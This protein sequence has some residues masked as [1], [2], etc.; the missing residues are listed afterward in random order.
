MKV[1][2]AAAL[3][4]AIVLTLGVVVT[5][6]QA[7]KTKK[8]ATEGEVEGFR[9]P[10]GELEFYGD[11]HSRKSKCEKGREV[12]LLYHGP[13]PVDDPVVGTDVTDGTGDW[14]VRSPEFALEGNYA[15]E[16][17]RKKV[18]RGDKKLVCKATVS[19]DTL[20]ED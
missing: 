12:T 7:A 10:G 4:L 11:V 5:A 16:V 17:A 1:A 20:I 6:S 18:G 15:V 2:R 13:Q 9:Y 19:P 8:V 3:G 14:E